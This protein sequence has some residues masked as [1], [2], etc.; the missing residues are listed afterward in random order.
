VPPAELLAERLAAVLSVVYLIY[1]EG[2]GGRVD[3]ASEAIRLGRVLAG[4]MPG[5]P[6]VRG[7]LALMLCH[8]A[9]R[10]ARHASDELVLL[11]AQDRSLWDLGQ[12]EQGRTLLESAL[13]ME[14]RGPHVLQAAIAV[15][16]TEPTVD[17]PQVAA[18]YAELAD[19]THSPVVQLNHAVAIA[20]AGSPEVALALVDRLELASY[21]YFHST[22]A[23]LLRRLGRVDEARNAYRRALEVIQSEPERRFLERRL[24]ELA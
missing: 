11:E 3:L 8:D 19:R 21:P 13:R 9:R 20:Q 1:N 12:I 7:L 6:E 4:L 14:G 18:L 24:L 23:E 16:Q 5:E 2:Y 10:R 15:L 22:R 17:W